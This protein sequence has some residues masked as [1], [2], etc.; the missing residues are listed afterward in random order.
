MVKYLL[1]D[2][3][4]FSYSL[5]GI[6]SHYKDYRLCWAINKTLEFNFER[7]EENL[8]SN[9][10]KNRL[11]YS[12]FQYQCPETQV[13]FELISN[14][15]ENGYLLPEIKQADFILKLDDFYPHD[16]ADIIKKLKLISMINMV[17]MIDAEALPSKF[18]LL[19]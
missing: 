17:F 8:H 2:D 15:S 9:S 6:S 13:L 1:D 12:F 18:K 19:Q 16:P 7:Q 14:R 4:E 3:L 5:I 10:E 11:G